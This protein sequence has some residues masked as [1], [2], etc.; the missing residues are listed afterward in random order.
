[1]LGGIGLCFV[2]A[3]LAIAVNSAD[4]LFAGLDYF[5]LT[6][7]DT[8]SY[9]GPIDQLRERRQAAVR[10]ICCGVG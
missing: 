3:T 6:N 5:P 10:L 2:G 9:L 4:L 7:D 8:F 1:M